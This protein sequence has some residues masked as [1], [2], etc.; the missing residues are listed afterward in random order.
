MAVIFD[1][2]ANCTVTLSP[3]KTAFPGKAPA[4]LRDGKGVRPKLGLVDGHETMNSDAAVKAWRIV[5]GVYYSL[6]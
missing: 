1:D 3:G 6:N 5:R 2:G 4:M